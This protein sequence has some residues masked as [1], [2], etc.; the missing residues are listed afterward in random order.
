[1]TAS[2]E[3]SYSS[4]GQMVIELAIGL[5]YTVCSPKISL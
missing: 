5:D 2:G 4:T 3:H 1:M